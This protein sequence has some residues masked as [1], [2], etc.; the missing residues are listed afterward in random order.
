MFQLNNWT[1]QF[2]VN[3]GY[4]FTSGGQQDLFDECTHSFRS[5]L[6][7][8]KIRPEIMQITERYQSGI[9]LNSEAGQFF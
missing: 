3:S 5:S 4:I 9:S 7:D 2:R 6:Q 8:N 1:Q